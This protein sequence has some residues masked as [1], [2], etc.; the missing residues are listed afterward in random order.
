MKFYICGAQE[1]AEIETGNPDQY[2]ITLRVKYDSS[3]SYFNA[4]KFRNQLQG[5]SYYFN[6]EIVDKIEGK[7]GPNPLIHDPKF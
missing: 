7:K 1:Q 4:Q 5:M 3:L 2:G 6:F